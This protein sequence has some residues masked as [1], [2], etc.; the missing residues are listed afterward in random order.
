MKV[1]CFKFLIMSSIDVQYVQG[2]PKTKSEKNAPKFGSHFYVLSEIG[3][4][5][6]M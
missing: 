3:Q 4:V 5:H 2:S 1:K 6:K